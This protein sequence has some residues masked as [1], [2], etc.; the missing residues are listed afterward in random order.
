MISS[1]LVGGGDWRAIDAPVHIALGN[2][3]LALIN[4]RPEAVANRHD[5]RED[6]RFFE[7]PLGFL[8]IPVSVDENLPRTAY[9]ERLGWTAGLI[10]PSESAP[11]PRNALCDA[12]PTLAAPILF[13]PRTRGL[14]ERP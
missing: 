3:F 11:F 9:Y 13:L 6:L 1:L 10:H 8:P 5:R 4:R 12:A 7:R 2:P 14:N